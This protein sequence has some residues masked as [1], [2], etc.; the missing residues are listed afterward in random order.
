MRARVR[1]STKLGAEPLWAGSRPLGRAGLS[2]R[3]VREAF[4]G[5]LER[6]G[7]EDVDLLWLHQED[8]RV[9]IEETVDAVGELTDAGLVGRV[10]ASNHPAWRV[11]RARAHAMATGVTPIDAFQLNHTYLALRPGTRHPDVDHRFELFS[12]EQR[13]YGGE[14]GFEAWAYSPVMSGRYDNPAK[15]MPEVYEHIGNER[16]L[17]A[18]TEVATQTGATRGQVVLA[19][20]VA[21]GIR[22]ILGG[23]KLYQLE[24][25]IDGA[26]LTLSA[27]QLARLDAAA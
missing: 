2:A 19:W 6:L 21:T 7:V 18:L 14:H 23:S 22:P 4:A 15:P 11:E 26:A 5:S 3:A 13:D 17:A 9:P 12:D 1:I 10:G 8:R 16:R 24:E 25:A 20:L 27:E